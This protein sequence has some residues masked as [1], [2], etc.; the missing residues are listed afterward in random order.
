MVANR[1]LPLSLLALAVLAGSAFAHD[2]DPK[3][4][5]KRPMYT[6]RGWKNRDRLGGDGNL[7]VTGPPVRFPKNNV[8][9]LSWVPLLALHTNQG[10][11]SSSC[12]GYTSPSGR[13]YAIIG[14]SNGTGYVEVTQPGSPLFIAN[15]NGPTS[16][17]RDVRT[18]STYA[19]AVTEGGGGIQVIDLSNIDNG[20]VT[21]VNTVNED[22]VGSTHTLCINQQSGYLYRSGGGQNGLRIYDLNPNPAAPARVG[23]WSARYSHEVSVFSYTSG[24]AAGKEI[25]YVCG[26]LNGGFTSPGV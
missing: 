17:W 10:G 16:L 19:Y 14:L 25:A 23:T 21:L 24:P 11:N 3:L 4:L 18:Y 1:K 9:L 26:G 22:S 7:L 12:Y 2:G 8:T 15:I 6:G 5:D 20:V 13:E